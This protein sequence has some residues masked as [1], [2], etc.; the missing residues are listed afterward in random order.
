MMWCPLH[1][2]SELG[3]N[4]GC[5]SPAAATC[6]SVVPASSCNHV[7]TASREQGA[8]LAGDSSNLLWSWHR[9][10]GVVCSMGTEEGGISSL[11]CRCWQGWAGQILLLFCCLAPAPA[12]GKGILAPCRV[13]LRSQA[14]LSS[15]CKGSLGAVVMQPASRACPHCRDTEDAHPWAG[16]GLSA[17]GVSGTSCLCCLSFPVAQTQHSQLLCADLDVFPSVRLAGFCSLPRASTVLIRPGA[18]KGDTG[19]KL[20]PQISAVQGADP[21][22]CILPAALDACHTVWALSPMVVPG[23]LGWLG[24]VLGCWLGGKCA[25]W[26][27]W[28]NPACARL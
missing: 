5:C 22:L 4:G 11:E 8:L 6:G 16:D 2:S 1:L 26:E 7:T 15:P 19:E 25:C 18:A 13:V 9:G 10:S 23:A 27:W 14:N 28:R 21:G 17:S 24:W 20:K 12:S 3:R